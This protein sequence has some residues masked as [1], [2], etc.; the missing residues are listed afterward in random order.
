MQATGK[1]KGIKKQSLEK[2]A[3]IFH[4]HS[5]EILS[6]CTRFFN[7]EGMSPVLEWTTYNMQM[8]RIKR[9]QGKH[10]KD[11]DEYKGCCQ[12]NSNSSQEL[13]PIKFYPTQTCC[14]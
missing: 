11:S 3:G 9:E 1:Y 5:N 6:T 10:Y 8:G 2:L 14:H 4:E 7:Y 13:S 12:T